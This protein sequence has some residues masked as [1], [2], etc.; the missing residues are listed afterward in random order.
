VIF[1]SITYFIFLFTVVVLYWSLPLKP[2][3]YLIFITSL[4]FYGFWKIEFIP[5]M[6]ISVIADYL[7]AIKIPKSVQYIKKRLLILSLTINLGLLF[8]FKYLIFFSENLFSFANLLG[9]DIDPLILNII[10]PLGISFYTFQTISYTVDVYRENISPEKN[11][12]LYACYVTFFPQLVAGPILRASEVIHQFFKRPLFK[13]EHIVIGIRR[14][15]YGIFLKVVL[16]DNIASYVDTGFS[17]SIEAMSAIDVWTLGFLF[18]FQI[19]FD[20]SAYSHIAIGSA[21]LMGIHFPENFN[22]PYLASSPRDFWKRWHISLSS[23]IRDYL[24]LPLAGVKIDNTSTGGLANVTTQKDNKPLFAAWTIMGLWHGA[25]WTFVLWG[26]YHALIIF[27]YRK[28]RHFTKG[29]N[30]NV[31]LFG[32]LFL[33][34]PVMMI[35]WIPFRAESISDALSMWLKVITPKAYWG[36]GMK[37]NAYLVAACIMVSIVIVWVIKNKLMPLLNR[38]NRIILISGEALV[39]TVLLTLGFL[40]LRPSN[41]FIYFQF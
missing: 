11:F 25:N 32:G 23:W 7:I 31:K 36:L 15:I 19:Y 10:L 37:E 28:T 27:I 17:M 2:R 33:T 39:F 9:I 16:A 5:V 18:G 38:G 24:Y 4:T 21:R 3:L 41:Q 40:F 35:S 1:N 13:W 26:V 14:I 22:F 20:F 8:Y 6:L 30:E 29:F 34:L 12:I